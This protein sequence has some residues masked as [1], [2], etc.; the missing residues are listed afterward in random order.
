MPKLLLEGEYIVMSERLEEIKRNFEVMTS[1][2]KSWLIQQAEQN[3]VNTQVIEKVR[4]IMERYNVDSLNE[5]DIVKLIDLTLK[6][7]YKPYSKE[8]YDEANEI[9]SDLDNWDYYKRFY[10]LEEYADD[11]EE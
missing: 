5:K 8:D 10:K 4:K 1:E 3:I 6:D 7:Y 2:E 11:Y 9:G